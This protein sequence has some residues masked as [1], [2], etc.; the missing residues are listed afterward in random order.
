MQ[1]LIFKRL[2]ILSNSSKSANQFL[3]SP[4]LNLIT[5]KD[6]NVGKTTLVKLL[7][8]G[9]GCDPSFDSKWKSLDCETI[10]EFTIGDNIYQT[11]RYHGIIEIRENNSISQ[12]YTKIT[13]EYSIRLANILGF[14]ALLPNR[15]KKLEVPPPAYYFL[16]FYIDQ[17]K[18]WSQ[19][20]NNFENLSQYEKWRTPIIQ[21]HVGLLPSMYFDFEKE[22]IEKEEQQ[23][24]IQNQIKDFD[25]T[26]K[27]LNKR[28][29]QYN[30]TTLNETNFN[31]I[32]HEIKTDLTNLQKEQEAT[33]NQ[34]TNLQSDKVFFEQ[35]KVISE[36]IINELEKDYKFTIENIK[37]DEIE[38]P[39]C[40]VH[41]ENSIFNRASIL[42]D[43][44]QV[45]DQLKLI[46]EKLNSVNKKLGQ[47][48][49]QL[50]KIRTNIELINK[51]Y[52]ITEGDSNLKFNQIIENIAGN[53]MKSNIND[54]IEMCLGKDRTLNAQIKEIRGKQ[55]KILSTEEKERINNFFISTFQEYIQDI[56][57][58]SI[59]LSQ[60]KT[61]LSYSQVIKEGGAAEGSRAILAY[62]LTIFT[63]VANSGN[64]IKCALVIDTPN[65]QEQSDSNYERIA[66]ILINKIKDDNQ[67]FLCA[68][69]NQ[70]LDSYRNM[71]QTIT[72]NKSQ[73]LDPNKYEEIKEIFSK[74]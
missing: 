67:I 9:L 13:G 70:H 54:E 73:L 53:S 2:L 31:K 33:L 72:L 10:V 5:A 59:N 57:S 38:C 22:K 41:H 7:F 45:E 35:Q 34:L 18:S 6:N 63:M 65:Q 1:S 68:M 17:K 49:E 60:I 46:N 32:T 28:I 29:P 26:L 74:K 42:K 4:S 56:G 16:P 50:K 48:N 58:E 8:W 3:F 40:G 52:A 15:E 21:Y 23:E 71:A 20:W 14:K 43:K 27:V 12:R 19:A 64:K 36:V 24:S 51:K 69:E 61:P 39:L 37:G 11:K 30:I 66:N 47:A 25:T 62:Y 44:I 55:K